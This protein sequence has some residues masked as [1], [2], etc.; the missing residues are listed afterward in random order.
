MLAGTFIAVLYIELCIFKT[1]MIITAPTKATHSFEFFTMFFKTLKNSPAAL[2]IMLMISSLIAILVLKL[3]QNKNLRFDKRGF[4]FADQLTQGENHIMTEAEKRNAFEM[5]SL[6]EPSGVILARDKDSND[7]L[8]VPFSGPNAPPTGNVL[9]VG[10]SGF[11]KTSGVLLGNIYSCIAAGYSM[12]LMDPKGEIY[13][14]TIAAAKSKGYRYYIFDI[15]AGEFQYSDGWDVL[16]IVREADDP[17]VAADLIA[18]VLMRNI[19]GLSDGFWDDAN[20][21]LIKLALLTVAIGQG[22]TPIEESLTS[23]FAGRTLAE[24]YALIASQDMEGKIDKLIEASQ[25][26]KRILSNPFN[27]W[28]THSQKDSI[29]SGLA[30]KLS[31]LNNQS[32]SRILSEDEIDFQKLNDE[33]TIIYVVCSDS[34]STY[35]CILALFTTLMFKRMTEIADS[36][37]GKRLDIPLYIFFEEFKNIGYVPDLSVKIATLRSRSINMIFCYQNIAQLMDTYSIEKGGKMEW[38]TITA[39]CSVQLCCGIHPADTRTA[40][41]FSNQSRDMTI[42]ERS[43][44]RKAFRF[45]KSFNSD[46]SIRATARPVGRKVLLPSDIGNITKD[47]ILICNQNYNVCI[48]NKYFYKYHPMYQYQAV[49]PSG[50]VEFDEKGEPKKRTHFEHIPL[51]RLKQ[52]EAKEEMITGE[53]VSLGEKEIRVVKVRD[54]HRQTW[55]KMNPVEDVPKSRFSKF[56]DMLYEEEKPQ[57]QAPSITPSSKSF[58]DFMTPPVIPDEVPIEEKDTPQAKA[59]IEKSKEPKPSADPIDYDAIFDG[60]LF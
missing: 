54:L 5:T 44:S 22:Y 21:N 43:E 4:R 24:V 13:M 33:K 11:R 36:K 7:V 3:L 27:T 17:Q 41:Y 38:E 35:Q 14:E 40:E 28:K 42:I 10:G 6:F 56:I 52:L 15:K 32:L 37:P 60:E 25:F 51:W 50:T 30:T 2:F 59:I 19:G 18:D 48:E 8:S 57:Q 53:K 20:K 31:I 16:K 45:A 49:G 29:K 39:N 23:G 47:E 55:D 26:N 58:D 34:D 1:F 46:P 9:V 12:V